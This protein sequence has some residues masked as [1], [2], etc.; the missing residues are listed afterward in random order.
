MFD[1]IVFNTFDAFMKVLGSVDFRS[2]QGD[3]HGSKEALRKR[4]KNR[5]NYLEIAQISLKA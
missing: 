2:Q 4:F 5:S 1:S 3:L